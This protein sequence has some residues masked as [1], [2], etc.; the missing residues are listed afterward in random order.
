[1]QAAGLNPRIDAAG[2]IF[3]RRAR[4]EAAASPVVFG[5]HIDSVPNGGDFDGD[6][7]TLAARGHRDAERRAPE[8][9]PPAGRRRVGQRGGRRVQQWPGRQ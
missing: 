6:L 2:N 8:D 4:T 9:S 3:G 7:G 5:S 1:M